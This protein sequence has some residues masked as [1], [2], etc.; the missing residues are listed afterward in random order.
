MPMRIIWGISFVAACLAGP[1]LAQQGSA[2]EAGLRVAQGRGYANAECYARVFAKHAVV[3]EHPNGRR[4]WYASSTPAYNAE[5]RNRCGIDRLQDVAV[6]NIARGERS[7]GGSRNSPVVAQRIG[8]A[9]AAQ[10]GYSGSDAA[11]FSRIYAVY[12]SPQPSRN[13]LVTYGISGTTEHIFGQELFQ[14]CRITR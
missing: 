12:A 2:Y 10:R 14:R 7:A 1:A 9:L 13:G 11:C 6:R 5:Q 3:V 4:R 8:L